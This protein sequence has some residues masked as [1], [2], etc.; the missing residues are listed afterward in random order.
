HFQTFSLK[1]VIK[2]LLGCIGFPASFSSA[3]ALSPVFDDN[4][5][6]EFSGEPH[7]SSVEITGNNNSCTDTDAGTDVDQICIFRIG[8]VMQC[9][10]SPGIRF[11][12][13]INRDVCKY[14]FEF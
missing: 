12:K 3:V 8:N 2:C 4:V 5:V 1:R 7:F 10:E 13:C 9:T 6:P 11:V 14:V